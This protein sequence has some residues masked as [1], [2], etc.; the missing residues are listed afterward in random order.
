[1]A[2]FVANKT[3]T[4]YCMLRRHNQ[5]PSLQYQFGLW[6]LDLVS[7]GDSFNLKEEPLKMGSLRFRVYNDVGRVFKFVKNWWFWFFNVSEQ[8]N[9]Q[10]WI[11]E[12]KTNLESNNR[13]IQLFQ[14]TS[15]VNQVLWMNRQRTW[16][17]FWVRFRVHPRHKFTTVYMK[18]RL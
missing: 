1:M 3:T 14:I 11:L 16:W 2:N 15:K 9:R 17:A 13:W 12:G 18:R 4:M 7:K 10:F 6:N 5:S 8:D